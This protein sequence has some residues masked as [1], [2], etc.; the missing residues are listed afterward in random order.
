MKPTKPIRFADTYPEARQILEEDGQVGLRGLEG[1]PD[2]EWLLRAPKWGADGVSS[3]LEGHNEC[4]VGGDDWDRLAENLIGEALDPDGQIGTGPQGDGF[5][6]TPIAEVD[7]ER[8][9]ALLADPPEPTPALRALL[10][11]MPVDDLP[12]Y[13]R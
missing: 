9:A 3:T 1:D 4:P 10:D 12:E 7:E 5:V 2:A 11:S 6:G 8:L 13:G